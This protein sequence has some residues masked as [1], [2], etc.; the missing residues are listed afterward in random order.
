MNLV[1]HRYTV[2]IKGGTKHQTN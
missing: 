2:K 1:S